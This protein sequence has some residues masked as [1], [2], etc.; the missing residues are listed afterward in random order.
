MP[1]LELYSRLKKEIDGI[2]VVDSHEHLYL[3]EEDYLKMGCDFGRLLFQYNIDDLMSAGMRITNFEEFR[4]TCGFVLR[5]GG[6]P[7]TGD[8]KWKFIEPY[9]NE[10]RHTGYSRALHHTI[11][12]LFGI[13]D[14]NKNTWR[15]ISENLA[16][17]MKP[18][19]YRKLLKELCGLS[20]IIA[21]VDTHMKPGMFE[22]MDRD[23]F[24]FAARFRSFTYAYMPGELENLE[25]KFNRTIRSLDHLIDTLDAQFDLWEK[26]G[27]VALKIADAYRRD[28]FY[29]DSPREEADSVMRRIFTLQRITTFQETLSGSEAR[30]FENY[31]THRVLERAE[32]RDIPVIIHTGYQAFDNNDIEYSR[33]GRLTNLF[34]KFPKLRFHI[35][36]SS[37]PWMM[38]AASLAKMYPNVTLDLTWTQVIVPDGAREGLSHMIDMVPAN[39]IHGFGGDYLVPESVWGALEVS[40]ENIAHVLAAKVETGHMT[41]K[42]AV[43]LAHKILHENAERIFWLRK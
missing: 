6:K 10:V 12:K 31:M 35:L 3:P 39:K 13:D 17:M 16:A 8:E 9:W 38:E 33:V 19:V 27:R 25:E 41:E 22:H 37:Y 4:D 5:N 26:E 24:H 1:S 42:Q 18:G 11:K 43:I 36:H 21:D 28:I 7:L 14:L 20:H 40:R 30:P 23:L 2:P 15:D 34:R 32:E 29:E